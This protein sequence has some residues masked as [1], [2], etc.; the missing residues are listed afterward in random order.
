[1]AFGDFVGYL[2]GWLVWLAIFATNATFA[3][4][5]ANYLR[6]WFP[7]MA[8]LPH[9]L[10]AA[11]LVW[12]ATLLNCRGIRIVG[13]TSVV[14]TVL[15]FLPFLAMALLGLL[16]WRFNPFDPFLNP[17]KNAA[18]AFG[19]GL[20]LAVWSYSGFEKLS[21]NAE[22]VERPARAFP[23]A[24]LIV[25]PLVAGSYVIPTLV[26]LAANG[27]WSAWGESHFTAAAEAI[28]GP[29]LGAAMAAGGLASNASLLTVTILGQSRLPMVLA[30]DGFFPAWLRKTHPRFGTP[31]AS[32]ILG[33]VVLSALSLLR[34][35]QL[36]GMFALIQSF[37]Y[38][39]IFASLFRLRRREAPG[40]GE[41]ERFRIPLGTV[42]LALLT[43]PSV[44]LV[45]LIVVQSVWHD[46]RF[47]RAQAAVD[48]LVLASGPLTYVL[49]RRFRLPQSP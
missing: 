19:D 43:A 17:H 10:V 24:L 7:Q 32:L 28:G 38:L 1:M 31:V 41:G 5:F 9:F 23:I 46:G 27:D 12:V 21:V 48:L 11:G 39:L 13:T 30:E 45:A 15:I 22:E 26:A 49:L 34:F 47:D 42:G 14:L 3:V 6:H 35:A 33:G 4:L 2:A 20:L 40:A 29:W 18:A 16:Q 44:V 8:P 25:L 37:A 36:A